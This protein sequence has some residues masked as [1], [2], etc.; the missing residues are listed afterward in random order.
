[1]INLLKE[2][3]RFDEY[4][5][6]YDITD[7]M[8]ALK[9]FHSYRVMHLCGEIADDLNLNIEDT[10][11]AMVIG[12]LHDYARF[13]QWTKYKTFSDIDSVDH[14]DLAC[15]L[16][17]ENNEIEKF[18]ID[19][20]YYGIIYDAIKYH[21][22][23]SY[24]QNLNERSKLFCKLIK[25]A[26]KLDIFYLCSIGDIKLPADNS[27]IS[28]LIDKEFYENKLLNKSNSKN[29]NEGILLKLSMIFDLNFEYSFK[30]LKNT[31]IM[32]EIF[33]KIE[34]KKLF[35]PYFNYVKDI[36]EKREKVY[37]RKKI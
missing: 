2:F 11:L 30:Y 16:L 28:D 5:E 6:S 27:E 18:N 34:N 19:N 10:Y 35:E 4:V 8:I 20:K 9:Y 22:K 14:G 31:K 37:V 15:E 12:L 36:V 26:D 17:F 21:N 33:N 3:D 24:P 29:I 23:Y 1:M 7:S 32:D 13:T 25:D